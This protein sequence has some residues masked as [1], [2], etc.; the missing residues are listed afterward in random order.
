MVVRVSIRVHTSCDST[1]ALLRRIMCDVCILIKYCVNC[2]YSTVYATKLPKSTK[3]NAPLRTRSR[4][5]NGTARRRGRGARVGG[6]VPG[7]ACGGS[8]CDRL[9]RARSTTWPPATYMSQTQITYIT[10]RQVHGVRATFTPSNDLASRHD[11]WATSSRE[12]R[13][14]RAHG[15]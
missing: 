3:I 4:T 11:A 6:A 7:P 15:W 13:R 9:D 5:A 12:P 10:R 1:K 2:Y 8:C 14:G